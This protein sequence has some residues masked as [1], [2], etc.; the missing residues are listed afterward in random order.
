M[1]YITSVIQTFSNFIA[2]EPICYKPYD[3][4]QLLIEHKI[5]PNIIEEFGFNAY[6]PEKCN[7]KLKFEGLYKNTVI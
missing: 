3:I 1:E 6:N 4:V 7:N 5:L 2:D